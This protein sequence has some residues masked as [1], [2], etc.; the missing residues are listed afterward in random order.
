MIEILK[1]FKNY[2]Y[3][4][5][6]LSQNTLDSYLRDIQYFQG[7]LKTHTNVEKM[8]EVNK[9]FV[10]TYLI[11]LQKEGKAFGTISRHLSSLKCFYQY[12]FYNGLIKEN[13]TLNLKSPKYERK[14]PKALTLEEVD[15]L[16]PQPDIN[17]FK[18]LRD[19]TMLELMYDTG[20]RV[21]QIIELN[22]SNVNSDIGYIESNFEG[23]RVISLG[24]CALKYL[25][26]YIGKLRCQDFR[27]EEEA[28]FVNLSGKR[29][30]RQ[31]FWKIVKYYKEK[32][33]I[34]KNITPYTLKK[35]IQNNGREHYESI[36]KN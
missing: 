13:P 15:L 16:L 32:A 9:T 1:K 20:M 2:L 18:G 34:D 12:L 19:K 8:E 25:N 21:S 14:V 3:E 26:L 22:V 17:S 36:R 28:L 35:Y 33:G 11:Q 24:N 31:G 6:G 7:Y 10:I 5:R 27:E 29:L 23:G 30:T 4:E